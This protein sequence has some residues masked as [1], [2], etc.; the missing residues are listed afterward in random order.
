MRKLPIAH[1]VRAGPARQPDHRRPLG[2]FPYTGDTGA[3]HRPRDI[4]PTKRA[5]QLLNDHKA[6]LI[7]EGYLSP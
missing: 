3:L 5:Q 4:E 1:K 2:S 6:V 7:E